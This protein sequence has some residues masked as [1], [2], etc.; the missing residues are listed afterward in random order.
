MRK[1]LYFENS[2]GEEQ[3]IKNNAQTWEEVVDAIRIFIRNCN[4]HK[5][6]DARYKYGKN[7][8]ESKFVPF[9]W[10]YTRCWQQEDGRTRI[11]VGS[12][13]E[14]F[15]WEGSINEDKDNYTVQEN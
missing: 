10:Y 5:L 9:K 12:H 6:N 15:I 1:R 7:F 13:T 3:V 14:F 2:K 11:D 8:D 4:V